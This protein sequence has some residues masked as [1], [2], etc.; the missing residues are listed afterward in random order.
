MT[1]LLCYFPNLD[2]AFLLPVH[3]ILPFNAISH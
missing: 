1:Q 3:F 2:S